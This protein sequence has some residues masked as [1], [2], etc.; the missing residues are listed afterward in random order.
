MYVEI[1][2]RVERV[3]LWV[4]QVQVRGWN[5][6]GMPVEGELLSKPDCFWYGLL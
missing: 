4:L 5:A 1:V 6:G 3:S 2:E